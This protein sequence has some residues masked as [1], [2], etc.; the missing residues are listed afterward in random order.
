MNGRYINVDILLITGLI[1]VTRLRV[2]PAKLL[3]YYFIDTLSLVRNKK[4]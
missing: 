3:Q 4:S 1:F 2:Y